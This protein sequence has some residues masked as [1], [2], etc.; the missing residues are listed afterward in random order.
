MSD[1]FIEK[2]VPQKRS[3]IDFLKIAGVFLCYLLL[4]LIT[5]MIP[6]LLFLFPLALF[7]GAY[8]FY[9]FI[10][11]SK[12]EHEYIVTNGTLDIDRI[13]GMR[14]R[15]RQISISA[16]DIQEI[17]N[18]NSNKYADFQ[19]KRVKI[20]DYSS[21]NK[22]SQFVY[23]LINNNGQDTAVIIEKDDRILENIYQY[24]RRLMYS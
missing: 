5:L 2:I 6:F 14:R 24:N 15:K 20:L 21:K 7:G 23:M 16:R 8:L 12:L 18:F 4:I 3:S 11:M 1:V 13:Y 19:R 10:A 17:S 22:D 9:L